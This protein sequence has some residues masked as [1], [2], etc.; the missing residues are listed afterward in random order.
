MLRD[1]V[2][3]NRSYRRFDESFKISRDT[4][5]SL[6]EL[7]RVCPS[8][9][10]RQSFKFHLTNEDEECLKVFETTSWAGYIKDGAPTSGERPSAYITIVSDSSLPKGLPADVGIL[11]Q[12]ILL[13]AC[14][15]GLG[16]CMIASV[17][18]DEL[19]SALSLS[20]SFEV[21][22]V[23]ALGKPIETVV[24]EEMRDGDF[25]Y[26]RDENKVHHVPKRSLDEIII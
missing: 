19:K 24:L 10:N 7:A 21:E 11:A 6:C 26:W 15:L 2:L 1:L 20:A 17:R 3:K 22:L 13:G 12:T 25:K 18:R 4:L 16:G 23:I 9:A 8:G 5:L 14:E